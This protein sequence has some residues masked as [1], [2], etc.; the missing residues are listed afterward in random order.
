MR[1]CRGD[2]V[3]GIDNLKDQAEPAAEQPDLVEETGVNDTG[4]GDVGVDEAGVREAEVERNGEEAIQCGGHARHR[5]TGDMYAEILLK[6][7]Q[8]ADDSVGE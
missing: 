3:G 1:I 2:I 8:P 7:P 6:G 5:T 4:A